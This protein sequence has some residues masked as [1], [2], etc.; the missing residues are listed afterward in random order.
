MKREKSSTSVTVTTF[1]C[2]TTSAL[3]H[4]NLPTFAYCYAAT[5]RYTPASFHAVPDYIMLRD[6]RDCFDQFEYQ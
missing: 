5:F 4:C 1:V 3:F 2:S 6:T